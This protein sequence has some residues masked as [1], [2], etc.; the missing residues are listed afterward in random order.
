[1]LLYMLLYIGDLYLGVKMRA[2]KRC[3][4]YLA[5]LC[6]FEFNWECFVWHLWLAIFYASFLFQFQGHTEYAIPNSHT[7]GSSQV[8]PAASV[9]CWYKGV[10][11]PKR[12][13]WCF[14]TPLPVRINH[15]CC[16]S[17]YITST[18]K[19][20]LSR[21]LAIQ[22]SVLVPLCSFK[23]MQVEMQALSWGVSVHLLQLILVPRLITVLYFKHLRNSY[24]QDLMEMWVVCLTLL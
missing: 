21:L 2:L 14:T 11:T 20:L 19:L 24:H 9:Q 10:F 3:F 15:S 13:Q 4:I 8:L 18:G 22:I 12:K 23:I 5:I 17:R 7:T 1:M 16:W 6:T